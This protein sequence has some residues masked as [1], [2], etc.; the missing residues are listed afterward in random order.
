MKITEATYEDNGEGQDRY[1]NT[2]IKCTVENKSEN[3]VEMSKGYALILDE[4][5]MVIAND[6]EREEESFAETNESYSVEY[7]PYLDYP[8]HAGDL[9]KLK[10]IVDV[11]S[12]RR[13]FFKLGE[14]DCPQDHEKPVKSDFTKETGDIRIHGVYIL[15]DRPYED[16]NSDDRSIQVRIYVRNIG[17]TYIEKVKAKVQLIDKEDAVVE[18][19]EDYRNVAPSSSN[20]INPY[21]SAKKGKL[22]GA[23]L[24]VSLSIYYA[25]EHFHAEEP[26][27]KY[28][29]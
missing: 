24:K 28:K 8:D 21:V 1:V 25:I 26:L 13:E 16:D 2:N 23:T 22:K 11:T 9:S 10:S 29:A 17:D 27:T 7:S 6:A 15:Q 14:Y 18:T 12:F 3:T 5:D 4:N 20:V 19:G